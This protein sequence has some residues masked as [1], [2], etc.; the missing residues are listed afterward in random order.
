M[1]SAPKPRTLFQH[2]DFVRLW[3]GQT[4]SVFGSMITATA[5]PF[6][7][8]LAL[9]ASPLQVAALTGARMI[10]ELLAGFVAGVWVDRLRRK[11]LMIAADLGRTA[12]LATVPIAWAFNA[13]YIEQLYAVAFV[14]GVLTMFFEVAY[15]SYLPAIVEREEL[16]DGNSKLTATNAAAEFG[17]FS[18][19]GW[20]VQ[21]FS[22]PIAIGVDA[23][24]FL[25]SA[26]F[27][28][29]SK[30]VEAAPAEP[31]EEPSIRREVVEGYRAVMHQPWLRALATTTALASFGFGIFG[32]TYILYVTRGLGFETGVL[33]VIFGLGG[34]SSLVGAVA[35]QRAAS[36]FGV[37]PSMVLG[38]GMMGLSMMLIVFADGGYVVAA[39]VILVAQQVLGD[40]AYTAYD[41]NAVSLRQ[42]ITDDAMQGRVNAFFRITEVFLLLLGTAAGGIIGEWLGLRVALAIGAGS[43]IAAALSLL[44]SPLAHV[45][46]APVAVVD[47]EPETVV[48]LP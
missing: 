5:L 7:A 19:G 9:D 32:A 2:P 17:G 36:R 40:G 15:R 48:P 11:P 33:G 3:A 22:G 25:V 45:R 4:V 21:I 38:I 1:T 18:V 42:S 24:T 27:L 14:T 34:L 23:V 47:V 26:L 20:L 43:V 39:A 8:I 13:L 10:P 29:S 31:A 46:S 37:G 44:L 30:R 28:R 35:A 12:A 41:V 16:L 6:T